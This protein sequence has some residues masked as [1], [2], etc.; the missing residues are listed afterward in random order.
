VADSNLDPKLWSSLETINQRLESIEKKLE[1]VIRLD[2]RV[3]N[4]EQVISRFGTRLDD[5]DA[6]ISK[7]ELWQAENNP[8]FIISTLKS[9]KESIDGIK[10]EVNTLKE[11][12]G[13][14]RGRRDIT[15]EVLKWVTG[16]LAAIIIYQATRG[17]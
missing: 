4:H 13:V 5:G 8:D 11:M 6:R 10:T 3:W 1:D 7:V 17:L 15:K 16:I 9:N 12:G 2:E 14:N